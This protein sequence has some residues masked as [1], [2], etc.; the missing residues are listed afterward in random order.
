MTAVETEGSHLKGRT[1]STAGS[2]KPVA[3]DTAARDYRFQIQSG[4]NPDPIQTP[5]KALVRAPCGDSASDAAPTHDT[6]DDVEVKKYHRN[7]ASQA[8]TAAS[9]SVHRPLST[10]TEP[11]RQKTFANYTENAF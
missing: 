5:W 10:K 6:Q 4:S 7:T 2:P 8:C 9:D 3:D 1:V 11:T